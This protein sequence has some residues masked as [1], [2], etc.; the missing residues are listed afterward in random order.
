[1]SL[2]AVQLSAAVVALMLAAVSSNNGQSL[3]ALV[4]LAGAW[5]R[6]PEVLLIGALWTLFC[7]PTGGNGG[8]S[9]RA[10]HA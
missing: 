6:S 5:T 8:G 1:M 7:T 4:M 9:G 2:L 3:G 10:R